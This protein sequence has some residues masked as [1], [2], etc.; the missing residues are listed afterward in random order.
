MK[1]IRHAYKRLLCAANE[2]GRSP[3]RHKYGHTLRCFLRNETGALPRLGR[4]FPHFTGCTGCRTLTAAKSCVTR[5]ETGQYHIKYTNM[6]GQPGKQTASIFSVGT[7]PATGTNAVQNNNSAVITGNAQNNGRNS[8]TIILPSISSAG[9]R[10][11]N[12]TGLSYSS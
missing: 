1:K 11:L 9:R 10:I 2:R 6:T 8:A 5:H 12:G 7:A 3:Y 4:I